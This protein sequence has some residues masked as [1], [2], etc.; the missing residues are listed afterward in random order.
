MSYTNLKK[1]VSLYI[2]F[3][4]MAVLMVIVFGVSTI[5]FFEIKMAEDLGNS[6]IAFYAADSGIEKTLYDPRPS[7][8][9]LI[10]PATNTVTMVCGFAYADCPIDEGFSIDPN[11]DADYFCIRSVGVYEGTKRAIQT[12]R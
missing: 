9:D 8:S 5:L 4:I 2:A 11:C 6:V 10:G 3:M 12:N 7:H 1:G